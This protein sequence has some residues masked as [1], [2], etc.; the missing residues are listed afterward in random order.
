MYYE[1]ELIGGTV[2]CPVCKERDIGAL[3]FNGWDECVGCDCCVTVKSAEEY[4]DELE[5]GRIARAVQA[6]LDDRIE[7]EWS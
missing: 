6:R 7:E 4:L 2:D 3:Y 1:N 5:N